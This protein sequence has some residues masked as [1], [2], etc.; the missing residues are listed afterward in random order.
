MIFTRDTRPATRWR[1]TVVESTTTPSTRKRTRTSVL[2][3]S[4]WTSEA[5]RSH[6]VGDHR[7]HEL[8]HRR[9]VGG[10]AQLDHLGGRLLGLVLDL[11][12]RL[13]Q[14]RQ[15]ADQRVDVRR[16]GDRA[17]HVVAG[18]PSRMSSSA[19]TFAGSAI[20]TSSVRRSAKAIGT[21]R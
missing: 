21:A 17:A 4:K 18:A 6:R 9:L 8:D 3:G 1:G 19:S 11:L 15:L 16:R 10:L 12:H 5:P 2:L 7:V 13:L 20:A 14:L